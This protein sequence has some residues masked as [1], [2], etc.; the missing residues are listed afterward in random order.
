DAA[1]PATP[2]PSGTPPSPP[3]TAVIIRCRPVIDR[4]SVVDRRRRIG[5]IAGRRRIL[6]GLPAAEVEVARDRVAGA[7]LPA[8]R[9][10]LAAAAG[11][12]DRAS[13]GN[14]GDDL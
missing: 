1:S 6:A 3:G 8:H 12:R 13:G 5:R 10:P 2:A 11:H 7:S 4:R 14:E 9:A